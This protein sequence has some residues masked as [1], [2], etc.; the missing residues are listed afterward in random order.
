MKTETL[1][2]PDRVATFEANRRRLWQIAY[3]MLGSRAEADDIVQDAYLRWHAA[4]LED[5]H[6]PQAWLVTTVTRLA[7]DRLRQLRVERELYVGPWLP[8]PLVSEA[9]PAADHAAE[10]ASELSVAFLALLERLA[11]EERAAFLLHEFFDA[12]YGEIAQA[13]GKNEAACRQIV[14]RARK[15]IRVDR[16]RIPVSRERVN[17]LLER[18]LSAVHAYDQKAVLALLAPDATWTTD[19]GGKVRAALRVLK[20]A[21]RVAKFAIGVARKFQAGVEYRPADVNGEPG[22]VLLRDG[23][24]ESVMSVRTDGLRILEVHVIRNPDKLRRVR[25]GA[26]PVTT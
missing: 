15:R 23:E 16:P 19:G 20:G 12:G 26:A 13:L 11:P 5:V 21:E 17:A 3:R 10:L 7:I 1:P 22:F 9:A 14:S 24:V 8:E 4:P 6:T 25:I 18:F 2:T